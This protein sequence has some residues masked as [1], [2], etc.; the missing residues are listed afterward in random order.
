ML[1]KIGFNDVV[2]WLFSNTEIPEHFIMNQTK[3]N[4]IVPYLTEQFWRYPELTKM[5]NS[6][7]DLHNI[8]NSISL[9]KS[10]QQ[11]IQYRSLTRN[12]LWKYIPYRK[13]D[14][15]QKVQ[16]VEGIQEIDAKSKLKMITATGNKLPNYIMPVKQDINNEE[17]LAFVKNALYLEKKK[18]LKKAVNKELY[19]KELNQ[20][21]I[22]E[23]ELTL[24]NVKLLK[25]RNQILFTFIDNKNK[26]R[27]FLKAFEAK[28]YVS[29]HPSVIQNDYLVTPDENF[30]EYIINDWSLLNKLKFAMNHNY[31]R[32]VNI[33]SDLNER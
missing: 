27:Y 1:I 25:I 14:Y 19:L 28:I 15:I 9:L 18:A 10:I 31:K 16:D 33:N 29:K 12:S 20:E 2:N 26:K 5:F 30:I 7:N 3:L 6:T 11:V 13:I 24:F 23:L 4:S 32:I 22:D 8:P 17:N 21:I